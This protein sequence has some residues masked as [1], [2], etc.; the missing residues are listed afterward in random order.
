LA[1][2][3]RRY[4]SDEPVQACPPSASY[5]LR[6]FARRNKRALLMGSIL[7]AA[8]MVGTAV[9]AW[10]A[11]R[12]EWSL[13]ETER[14]RKMAEANYTQA[15]KQRTLAEANYKEAERQ[16]KLAESS[17]Q[18][19][20]RAVDELFVHLGDDVSL[21]QAEFQPLRAELLQSALRYYQEFIETWKDEP[22][23]QAE[24]AASYRKVADLSQQIG[25]VPEALLAYRQALALQRKLA[26]EAGDSKRKADL[27]GTTRMFAHSQQS[28]G[29]YDE[30]E[31]SYE[32]ALAI[33]RA[34]AE[35]D[36]KEAQYQSGIAVTL[37]GLGYLYSERGNLN[38]SVKCHEQSVQIHQRLLKDQPEDAQLKYRLGVGYINLGARLTDL[39]RYDE[40]LAT[41][42][43][44][45][46]LLRELVQQH[47]PNKKYEQEIG[48]TLNFIGDVYRNNRR[49]AGWF[50]QALAAYRQAREIQERLLQESPT[51]I[52]AQ[53]NLANTILNTGQVH[54]LHKDHADAL[55]A[56]DEAIAL[57]EKVVGT[58]PEGIYDLSALGSA[59]AERGRTLVALKRYEDAV[60]PYEK[61][62]ASR[63]R[64]VRM[65]PSVERYQRE[66]DSYRQELERVQN[67]K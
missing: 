43:K 50:E 29:K 63:E 26:D 40:A 41:H 34:L 7:A 12:A 22:A 21:N 28:T 61:A 46:V 52:A 55:Q 33:Y 5:R 18:Q 58:N 42:N 35:K 48:F 62:V 25:A 30:A 49:Q 11:I 57:L 4:L 2:D 6:K 3:V 38:D 59:Y 8:L 60:A 16:R 20:R 64:L 65:A 19:A 24:I 9:S 56:F 17:Y 39:G 67:K 44:R 53:S 36:P 31:K 51:S 10:Q 66:L 13:V 1:R 54:R 27:A 23:K 14:Q 32:Q 47:G 45:L 37:D 15:E